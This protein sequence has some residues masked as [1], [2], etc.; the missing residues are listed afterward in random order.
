[1]RCAK[2]DCY[3]LDHHMLMR[4]ALGLRTALVWRD[5]GGDFGGGFRIWVALGEGWNAA[6]APDEYQID[7]DGVDRSNASLN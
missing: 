6:M 5:L 7:V 3:I 4:N 1:V 2:L